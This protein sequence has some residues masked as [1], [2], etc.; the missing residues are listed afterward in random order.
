MYELQRVREREREKEK[1]R[2]KGGS[3]SYKFSSALPF[4][5]K[6]KGNCI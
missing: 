2:E 6:V 1:E 5:S 3:F 4:T